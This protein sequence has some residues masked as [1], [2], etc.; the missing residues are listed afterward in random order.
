M[1]ASGHNHDNSRPTKFYPKWVAEYIT[2][3][4]LADCRVSVQS[5]VSDIEGVSE[6]TEAFKAQVSSFDD[7]L[8]KYK[9]NE[10]RPNREAFVDSAYV[11]SVLRKLRQQLTG[12]LHND[13]G[14]DIARWV[15][16]HYDNVI[17]Y[18][19]GEDD[20]PGDD[21]EVRACAA[22]TASSVL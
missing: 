9:A 19:P 12:V 11:R 18:Q 7:L 5:L 22:A 17:L 15:T 1:L 20:P 16:E 8:A 14:A 21:D 4:Y 10:A 3:R 2:E 13:E 6:E